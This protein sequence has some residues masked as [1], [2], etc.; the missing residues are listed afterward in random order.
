MDTREASAMTEASGLPDYRD[1]LDASARANP[2]G[3]KPAASRR[4][5]T[6]LSELLRTTTMAAPLP[7]LLVAFLFGVAVGRRR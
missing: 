6:S 7:S 1:S 3:T 4:L 5:L 2:I